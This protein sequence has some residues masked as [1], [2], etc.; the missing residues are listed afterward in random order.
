MENE[1]NWAEEADN[2]I[3]CFCGS[4]DKG[5]IVR[6]IQKGA[7]TAK[8]INK[9]TNAGFGGQCMELNP[10]KRCCHADIQELI[11]IYGE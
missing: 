5:T 4:V 3:V 6:A 7:M 2:T 10:R 9:L 11:N 8:E 1:V